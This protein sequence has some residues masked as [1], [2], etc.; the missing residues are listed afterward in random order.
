MQ[1]FTIFDM[2][3]IGITLVLGLKGLFRGLIKEVFG[4]IAI[5]GAIFVASRF[6]TQTGEFI[7]PFLALESQSTIKLIGFI[8]SLIG[9]W[10]V[11][12]ILGIV[13]SKIFAESG[14]GLFDRIFGFFFGAAK[15]FLIFSVITYALYQVNSFRKVIDENTKGSFVTPHLLSVGSYIMK[16][17]TSSLTNSA[18]KMVDT[19]VDSTKEG[20]EN[21]KE[22]V[23]DT[24]KKEETIV[25]SIQNKVEDTI[26]ETTEKIKENTQKQI[27]NVANELKNITEENT[28]K[29]GN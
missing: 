6:A 25:E 24:K 19:V 16:I 3:I 2:V 20:M 7:A 10:F 27:E 12:Y 15:I 8:V 9:F 28:Q 4:I 26:E 17:D 11:V 14:L 18:N 5:I 29:E 23:S 22:K 21:I 1:E 13:F